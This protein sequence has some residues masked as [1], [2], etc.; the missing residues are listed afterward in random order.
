MDLFKPD[1][2]PL[3]AVEKT[4]VFETS[5]LFAPLMISSRRASIQGADRLAVPSPWLSQT[6]NISRFQ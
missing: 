2:L 3:N 6:G 1:A 5:H 4:N